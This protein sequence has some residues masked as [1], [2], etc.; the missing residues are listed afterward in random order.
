[1]WGGSGAVG[2][3]F[4]D[5]VVKALVGGASPKFDQMDEMTAAAVSSSE[6]TPYPLKYGNI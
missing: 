1:L 4:G 5:Y 3:T 2:F 6:I